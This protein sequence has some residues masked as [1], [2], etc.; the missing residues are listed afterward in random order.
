[1]VEELS[2]NYDEIIVGSLVSEDL[3]RYMGEEKHVFDENKELKRINDELLMR[4]AIAKAEAMKQFGDIF[5]SIKSNIVKGNYDLARQLA[6]GLS[7]TPLFQEIIILFQEQPETFAC[8]NCGNKVD[9]LMFKRD[10]LTWLRPRLCQSCEQRETEN[11][12]ERENRAYV[13]FVKRNMVRL[14][15]SVGVYGRLLEGSYEEQPSEIIQTCKRAVMAR[16][17]IY[18]YGDVGRGK[19]CLSV[20]VLKDVIQTSKFSKE[21]QRQLMQ[22]IGKFR[23]LYR[24]IHVKGLLNEIKATYGHGDYQGEQK[25]IEEYSTL[26][27]LIIDDIG[28]EKPSNWL[29]EQLN[30]IVD[31]RNN[32]QLKTIYTSNKDPD[33]LAERLDARIISRIFQ[34]CE[35]IHLT[36]QDRRRPDSYTEQST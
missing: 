22:D 23:E 2:E 18:I 13:K 33:A 12:I 29:L 24:F 14:L 11:E 6:N 16:H 1:M 7:E 17:G 21:M 34:Q 32:R 3:R 28:R 5:S 27:L 26:Q 20:A 15:N 36:G 30:M 35:I 8:N 19:S 4:R 9:G 25:I 31:F 10:T